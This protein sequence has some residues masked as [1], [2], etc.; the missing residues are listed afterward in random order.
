[1]ML[2]WAGFPSHSS[3][4]AFFVEPDLAFHIFLPQTAKADFELRRRAR[5]SGAKWKKML[6]GSREKAAA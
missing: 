6:L 1:M 2:C 3:L 5:M 4:K